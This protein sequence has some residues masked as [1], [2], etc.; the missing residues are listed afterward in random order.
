[1][2]VIEDWELRDDELQLRWLMRNLVKS[3]ALLATLIGSTA[4]AATMPG[5][6]LICKV[7]APGAHTPQDRDLVADYILST[8]G[9]IDAKIPTLSP[10]EANWLKMEYDDQLA[11]HGNR[12]NER[13]LAATASLEY[14]KKAA[15]DQTQGIIATAGAIKDY[16]LG[17]GL[18][19]DAWAKLDAV[20]ID[21]HYAQNI[22]KLKDAGLLAESDLPRPSQYFQQNMTLFGQC[23]LRDVIANI[24]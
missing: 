13:S 4:D 24:R 19:V 20:I 6:A 15:K 10:S 5:D 22:V 3:I 18:E 23:I 9:Q 14:A 8:F 12:W 11:A 1:M 7:G 2:Y 21:V 17:T 16:K